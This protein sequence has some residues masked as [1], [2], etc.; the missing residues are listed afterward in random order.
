MMEMR[1]TQEYIKK[2]IIKEIMII[3]YI[4]QEYPEELMKKKNILKGLQINQTI[5]FIQNKLLMK[6]IKNTIHITIK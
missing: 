6:K 2:D 4:N 1:K 5:L 3:I